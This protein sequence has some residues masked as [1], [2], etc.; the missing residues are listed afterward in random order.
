MTPPQIGLR[1]DDH[2]GQPRILS[3]QLLQQYVGVI[4]ELEERD[5]ERVRADVVADRDARV[6]DRPELR[7]LHAIAPERA[8]G[9]H[10]DQRA[11]LEEDD[12]AIGGVG[13]L[14]FDQ[15]AGDLELP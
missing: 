1:I 12:I 2:D 11:A 3:L 14:D 4:G 13:R 15:S 8:P 5:E 6:V 7:D 9:G 10:A